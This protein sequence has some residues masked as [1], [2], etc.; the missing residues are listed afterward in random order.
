MV[1]YENT[2][3]SKHSQKEVKYITEEYQ[4]GKKIVICSKQNQVYEIKWTKNSLKNMR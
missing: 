4:L 3:F 2:N 1:E